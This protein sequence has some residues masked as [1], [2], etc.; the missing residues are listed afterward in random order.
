MLKILSRFFGLILLALSSVG[1]NAADV[2]CIVTVRSEPHKVLI[3]PSTTPYEVTRIDFD[4]GF[5]FAG[6]VLKAP[7]KLKTYT[8]FDSKDRYVLIHMNSELLD[9]QRCGSDLGTSTIYSPRLELEL[10]YLC[11]L[12]CDTP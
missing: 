6:Q 11:Q 3:K 10:S 5:R 12:N 4:N 8:Y 7:Y 2:E 9:D 1:V